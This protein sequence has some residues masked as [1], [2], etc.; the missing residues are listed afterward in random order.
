MSD[1]IKDAYRDISSLKIRSGT[2]KLNLIKLNEPDNAMVYYMENYADFFTL[3]IQEDETKY[4]TLLKN[5]DVRL[6][7]IRASDPASPYYLYCQAE[8]ILQ[9]ATIKLKFNDKINAATDVFEAYKL[10]EKNAKKFP[11]FLENNKSLSIIHALA[12]SVPGWVRKIMGIKGSIDQGTK[13]ISM[14]ATRAAFENHIFKEE[15]VAIYSYILFYSNNRKEE[16]YALFDR[17]RL[18]HKLNPL[19][20]FL[21]ATMAQKTGRNEI[22][23][24]I[25]EERPKSSDYIPFYYLDFMYGKFKLYRLDKDADMHI[26]YF[27]THF[28]GKHYIKE[29]WQ[30]MAWYHMAVHNDKVMYKKCMVNCAKYGQSLIDEDIQAGKEAGNATMPN[31]VMLKARLLFDGGYYTKCEN[32]LILHSEKFV[33]AIHDGEYYY[34]LA[35]VM[36]ALKNYHDALDYYDLTIIKSDPGKYYACNA[37]PNAGLIYEQTKKYAKSKTYFEKCL[38][39]NPAGYTSSLHQKLSRDSSGSDIKNRRGMF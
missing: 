8:I 36:D 17:F 37:A 35:R 10:L 22:A 23:L 33:N 19:V 29:A 7:K 13:E 32:L 24:K 6:N 3:F 12:E 28:K 16:A 9:W 27:L 38:E 20:A 14:L 31:D 5:R 4:K 21:K 15:I 26:Q 2:Q 11:D 25:L 39:L 1:A 30:K 18:N 34:R